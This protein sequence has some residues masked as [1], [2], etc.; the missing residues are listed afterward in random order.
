MTPVNPPPRMSVRTISIFRGK[1]NMVDHAELHPSAPGVSGYGRRID[2]EPEGIPVSLKE[3]AEKR[4]NRNTLHGEYH[5][6][7]TC[8]AVP[9]W[10]TK[11][12]E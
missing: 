2:W 9:D 4:E 7:V 3:Y 6:V 11:I 5:S 12:R 10:R 8:D 1:G